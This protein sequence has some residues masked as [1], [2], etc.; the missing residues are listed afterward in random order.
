MLTICRRRN[1][2]ALLLLMP[3]GSEFRS[4][5]PPGSGPL[6][7]R[8][9]AV[10]GRQYG[11]PVIDARKWMADRYFFDSHHLLSK[12]ATQFTQRLGQQV[13]EPFLRAEHIGGLVAGQAGAVSPLVVKAPGAFA[14]TLAQHRSR[15]MPPTAER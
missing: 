13:L 3:E 6:I 5:Y 12:G 8:Y 2:R 4:W 11:V 10:L 1:I 14:P 7:D 15:T 9:L